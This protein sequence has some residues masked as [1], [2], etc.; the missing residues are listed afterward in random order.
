MLIM[1]V[2]DPIKDVEDSFLILDRREWPNFH[3][4]EVQ[5]LNIWHGDMR[6]ADN[7]WIGPVIT[8][9]FKLCALEFPYNVLLKFHD[10]SSIKMSEI[11]HENVVYDLVMEYHSRGNYP[12]GKPL[13]PNISIGFEQAFGVE[14]TFKCARVQAIERIEVLSED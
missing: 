8:I 14:L 11:N 13:P 7:V 5:N 1:K 3:D 10:C 4:A 2:F 6:P 12:D 9:S